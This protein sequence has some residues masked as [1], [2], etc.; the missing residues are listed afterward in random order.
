MP[1]IQEY[2]APSATSGIRPTEI[3]ERATASAAVMGERRAS[4][5]G[6][7]QARGLSQLGGAISQA[8]GDVGKFVDEH[9]TAADVSRQGAELVQ[10]Q[11]EYTQKFDAFAKTVAGDQTKINDPTVFQK[12]YEDN[13]VPSVNKWH[14]G[15]RTEEGSKWGQAEVQRSTEHM[16]NVATAET[17]V[18]AGHA[19]TL[20]LQTSI[21]NASDMVAKD[22][23][24]LALGVDT[25]R[26]QFEAALKNPNLP[27]DKVLELQEQLPKLL[28]HVDRKSVV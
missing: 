24:S 26:S 7:M 13:W 19:A 3:G 9:L 17:G 21:Q 20:N 5:A 15:F 27:A 14:E 25:V 28:A 4:I 8:A 22:P 2:N 12:F 10:R 16:Q 18:L 6:D 23:S 1:S 11:N